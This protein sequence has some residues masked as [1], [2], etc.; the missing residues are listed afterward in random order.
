[1]RYIDKKIKEI[2]ESALSEADKEKAI[3]K[4]SE[5]GLYNKAKKDKENSRLLLFFWIVMISCA[6]FFLVE[7]DVLKFKISYDSYENMNVMFV[8]LI[9]LWLVA[10]LC[11]LPSVRL[12]I[13]KYRNRK[14]AKKIKKENYEADELKK[15][16]GTLYDNN[17][18]TLDMLKR[19]RNKKKRKLQFW[20]IFLWFASYPIIEI[21]NV[22]GLVIFMTFSA[23]VIVKLALDSQKAR[24]K[25]I[26]CYKNEVIGKFL[27]KLNPNIEYVAQKL[28]NYQEA[29]RNNRMIINYDTINFDE[30]TRIR[31]SDCIFEKRDDVIIE[32]CNLFS[33]TK[34]RNGSIRF[35]GFFTMLDFNK[36]YKRLEIRLNN[37]NGNNYHKTRNEEFDRCF[38]VYADNKDA[39]QE[40]LTEQLMSFLVD[41]K[42]EKQIDFEII[43][44]DK[45]YIRFYTKDMFEANFK[46]EAVDELSIYQYSA[47]TEFV[48]GLINILGKN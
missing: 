34:T 11:V 5:R 10:V 39:I 25:Y 28:E 1:M 21:V 13:Q 48:D 35:D 33:Y 30:D 7:F 42:K 24:E 27:L 12:D 9:V 47:I 29:G 22:V 17:K 6:L 38:Y 41:F 40:Y 14:I 15:E 31:I 23:I 37:L 18:E 4:V 44:E 3:K 19:E 45:V 43:F 26:E 36:L 46:D 16:F 32:M 8:V 20:I 2:N